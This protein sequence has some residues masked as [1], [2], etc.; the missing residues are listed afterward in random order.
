MRDKEKTGVRIAAAVRTGLGVKSIDLVELPANSEKIL[1]SGEER[2]GLL[3]DYLREELAAVSELPRVDRTRSFEASPSE[4]SPSLDLETICAKCR[5]HC[6]RKGGDHG[7]ISPRTLRRV[8]AA[9]PTLDADALIDVYLSHVPPRS[10]AGSCIY[11]SASGCALPRA[12]R[13][14]V[15]NAYFCK[16]LE[17]IIESA[18]QHPERAIV[19]VFEAANGRSQATA[20]AI[21]VHN[22]RIEELRP[23]GRANPARRP[24]KRPRR[25]AK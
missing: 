13:S 9:D 19:G 1:L 6:C 11:H 5:G 10:Y 14:E 23:K 7:F 15:C 2:K 25:K 20:P 22:G 8:L 24:R 3:R 16:G 17:T 12:L 18:A 21:L 4:S